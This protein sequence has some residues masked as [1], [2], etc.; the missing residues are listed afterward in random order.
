MI[1]YRF[2]FRKIEIKENQKHKLILFNGKRL[3]INGVNRHEWSAESGRCVIAEEKMGY[4]LY[5]VNA[6]DNCTC[7]FRE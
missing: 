7:K 6:I 3:I 5:I 2:G 1:P 4:G